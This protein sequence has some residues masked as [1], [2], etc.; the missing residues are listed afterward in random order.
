MSNK[1]VVV[2]D[3]LKVVM[4]VEK[5]LSKMGFQV[6][7]ADEGKRA[8]ELVLLEKPD[9]VVSDMLLPGIHGADLCKTIK[10]DPQLAHTKVILMT[11]VYKETNYKLDMECGADGFIGKPLDITKLTELVTKHVRAKNL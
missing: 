11:G 9:V 2:D 4:L 6:Y 1:V 7:T 5:A 3:D 10:Q 8:L